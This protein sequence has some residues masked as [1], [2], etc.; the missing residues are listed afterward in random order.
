MRFFIGLV[1]FFALAGFTLACGI[2]NPN[3]TTDS[4]KTD[5]SNGVPSTTETSTSTQEPGA[6][7]ANSG[8]KPDS[9]ITD[10]QFD[11]KPEQVDKVRG[12]ADL[13]FG[14]MDKLVTIVTVTNKGTTR[15]SDLSVTARLYG[16]KTGNLPK[17]N[18]GTLKTKIA[19]SVARLA[20]GRSTQ[21][22]FEFG[23]MGQYAQST[24]MVMRVDVQQPAGDV[25]PI[26]NT[27]RTYFWSLL[28]E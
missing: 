24:H 25:N 3:T 5:T 14:G 8:A 10:V 19:K 28:G 20:P 17:E 2:F 26:N 21:V 27:S 11:P 23:G 13:I 7:L 18:P 12:V 1:A 22:I 16:D 15:L 9:A 4:S 6:H